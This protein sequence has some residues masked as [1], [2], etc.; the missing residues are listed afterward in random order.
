M[1][2]IAT[3]L[4]I[5]LASCAPEKNHRADDWKKIFEGDVFAVNGSTVKPSFRIVF[6]STDGDDTPNRY[7][8]E[9]NCFDSGYFDKGRGIFLSGSSPDGFGADRMPAKMRRD[10]ADGHRMRCP[11]DHAVIYRKLI[12]L[13]YEGAVL[14]VDGD[15]A[16]LASQSGLSAELGRVSQ[17]ILVD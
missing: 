7:R 9:S 16:R 17:M 10:T 8:I 15:K 11:D 12:D 2:F 3:A 4:L 14:S 5:G 13:M 6:Y 1:R